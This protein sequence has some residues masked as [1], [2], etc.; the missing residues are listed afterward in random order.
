MMLGTTEPRLNG[1]VRRGKID[2]A[3]PVVSGRRLWG[4]EHLLQA[5]RALGVPTDE[6]QRRLE[7]EAP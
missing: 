2:P 1:L 6:L 3:P 7:Q 4:R 5:A